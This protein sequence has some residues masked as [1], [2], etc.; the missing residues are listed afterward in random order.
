MHAA[1]R[2]IQDSCDRL[3]LEASVR[4]A[5][6]HTYEECDRV[7]D[8]EAL[9][10]SIDEGTSFEELLRRSEPRQNIGRKKNLISGLLLAAAE[11]GVTSRALDEIRKEILAAL[12]E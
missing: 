2:G 5:I 3:G 6:L 9:Q 11:A 1:R 12:K 7:P 8:N 4:D 10:R